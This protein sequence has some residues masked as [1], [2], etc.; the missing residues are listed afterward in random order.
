MNH[1]LAAALVAHPHVLVPPPGVFKI[2][3]HR[4]PTLIG[5]VFHAIAVYFKYIAVILIL[6]LLWWKGKVELWKEF[7]LVMIGLVG[8]PSLSPRVSHYTSDITSG[9]AVG[10]T[11]ASA[12]MVIFLLVL[13]A[14]TVYRMLFKRPV[15][16]EEEAEQK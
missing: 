7:F 3:G 8:V 6:L 2:A 9:S 16:I 4:I 14:F 11:G 10:S 1:I 15:I 12:G 13:L 5:Q